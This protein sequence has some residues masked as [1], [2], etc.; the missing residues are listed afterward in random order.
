M[1][2]EELQ[3]QNGSMRTLIAALEGE[4]SILR[5]KDY[6]HSEEKIATL[7]RSL[8][9]ERAMNAVLTSKLELYLGIFDSVG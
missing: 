7:E 9:S 2:K 4:L 1:T 5:A 6:S 3:K 8:E